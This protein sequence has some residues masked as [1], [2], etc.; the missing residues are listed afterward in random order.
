ME[1]ILNVHPF[2]TKKQCLCSFQNWTPF[3]N[4]GHS[5]R[6]FFFFEDNKIQ[7]MNE[8]KTNAHKNEG[9]SRPTRLRGYF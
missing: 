9:E 6:V 3:Y 7:Q 1:C 8:P 4:K 2:L 5:P